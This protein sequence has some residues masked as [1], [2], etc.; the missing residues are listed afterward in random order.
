MDTSTTTTTQ[1]AARAYL[2]T[3]NATDEAQRRDLL[4]AYWSPEVAYVDPLASVSGREGVSAVVAEVHRQFPG[5]VFSLVG[6]VDG[7]HHQ[8][9]FRWGLGPAGAEPAVIGFDVVVL[10]EQGRIA[11]VRGFLD[12]VPA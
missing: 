10:D 2:E 1:D 11:D 5:A 9:R 8:A 12:R 4:D 3:W 6:D 7:H